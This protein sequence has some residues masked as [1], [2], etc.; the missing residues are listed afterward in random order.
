MKHLM[1]KQSEGNETAIPAQQEKQKKIKTGLT[2]TL[3]ALI[4]VGA[5]LLIQVHPPFCISIVHTLI[6]LLEAKPR[7]EAGYSA[8]TKLK[9]TTLSVFRKMASQ[10]IVEGLKKNKER[11][12]SA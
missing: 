11:E 6:Y 1:P 2:F 12:K 7:N 9:T 10:S 4:Y 3:A 8:Y 5:L